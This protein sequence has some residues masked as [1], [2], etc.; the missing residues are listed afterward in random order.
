MQFYRDAMDRDQP[1]A[2]R[3]DLGGGVVV[4]GGL[5]PGV[6]FVHGEHFGT[7]QCVVPGEAGRGKFV[8]HDAAESFVCAPGGKPAA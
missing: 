4:A 6:G 8:A 3:A 2:Y 5:L 7:D 1:R